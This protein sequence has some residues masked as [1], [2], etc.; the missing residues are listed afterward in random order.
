MS[1]GNRQTARRRYDSGALAL[2][3][4]GLVFTAVACSDATSGAVGAASNALAIAERLT[5][6]AEADTFVR[7]DV[8]VRR[9]DNYGCEGGLMVGTSR[10]GGGIPWG[11]PDAMRSFVRFSL[12]A[13][14]AAS[15]VHADLELTVANFNMGTGASVFRV[16]VQRVLDAPPLTPWVEGNGT[17]QVPV[18]GGCTNVDLAGGVAWEATEPENQTQPP[19]DSAVVASAQVT[20]GTQAQGDV[21]RFDVTPLVRGWLS[22]AFVNHGLVLR[23]VT[24]D[25]TFR[26]LYF[27]SRERGLPLAGPRLVLT[28]APTYRCVGFGAPMNGSAVIVRG[29]R[30]LPLKASLLDSEGLPVTGAIVGAAPRLTVTLMPAS[31]GPPVDVT[32]RATPNGEGLG[33]AVFSFTLDGR[34]QYNLD[35]SP[36]RAPGEYRVTLVS[37]DPAE[38]L[39][40]P[41]CTGTFVVR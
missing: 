33:G 27:A 3:A 16:D 30:S 25:G 21:V 20:Q 29:P 13:V 19:F 11:G 38:Y 34:W 36:F 40:A 15:V 41:E 6:E 9:N 35:T 2:G 28:V 24:T 31:G 17:T 18:P 4:S 39:V 7:T 10:G 22:G 12:P 23:D 32:D 8:D 26:E 37:G 1:E 14:T 5:V